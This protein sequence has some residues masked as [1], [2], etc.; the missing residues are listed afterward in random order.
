MAE[1]LQFHCRPVKLS[2]AGSRR[3]VR[4]TFVAAQRHEQL[5]SGAAPGTEPLRATE[6]AAARF[7]IRRSRLRISLRTSSSLSIRSIAPAGSRFAHA[8]RVRSPR[9]MAPLL[10][11]PQR[12]LDSGPAGDFG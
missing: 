4:R 2:D 9:S 1:L 12:L 6:V 11:C 8:R 3:R 10:P 7:E 5:T